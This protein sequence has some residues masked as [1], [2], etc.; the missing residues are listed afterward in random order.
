MQ[1]LRG[2][3]LYRKHKTGKISAGR[4]RGGR[5]GGGGGGGGGGGEE[6]IGQKIPRR[7]R[8]HPASSCRAMMA[9]N[10]TIRG[11]RDDRERSS[12]GTNRFPVI[13][14][15]IAA[16]SIPATLRGGKAEPRSTSARRN[17][18]IIVNHDDV[19]SVSLSLS[20]WIF[21][22]TREGA[23][24]RCKGNSSKR[25]QVRCWKIAQPMHKSPPP[26][27]P[28]PSFLPELSCRGVL[29][30]RQL[31]LS[32]VPVPVPVSLPHPAD[33]FH[34]SFPSLASRHVRGEGRRPALSVPRIFIS[35]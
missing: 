13:A 1:L 3:D 25:D 4:G 17:G 31:L 20:Q 18:E 11:I 28:P 29:P 24:P 10:V 27:P 35:D 16:A 34:E 12:R 26:P 2:S 33:C 8:D 6:R 32:P 30:V 9:R 19:I 23:L 21:R 7:A 14:R 5:Q 15:S 22:W